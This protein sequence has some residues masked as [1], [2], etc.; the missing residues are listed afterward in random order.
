MSIRMWGFEFLLRRYILYIWAG[1]HNKTTTKLIYIGYV[2]CGF[3]YINKTLH[4]G[5]TF[6]VILSDEHIYVHTSGRGGLRNDIIIVIVLSIE[7]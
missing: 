1:H 2:T 4:A 3:C 7:K 5:C 6:C